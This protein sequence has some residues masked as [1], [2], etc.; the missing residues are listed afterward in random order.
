MEFLKENRRLIFKAVFGLLFIGLA[1]FFIR[2][3]QAEI[4]QVRE[5]LSGANS[6]W[7]FTG[8]L[9]SCIYIVS[10][11][12]MYYTSF[13]SIGKKTGLLTTIRVFLKRNFVSVFLPAGGVA[14]LAFFTKDLERKQISRTQ[15]H[16]ASTIYAFTGIL[17]VII[18][19]IPILSWAMIR[20]SLSSNQGFAFIAV[21]FFV[22]VIGLTIYSLFRQR[23]VYSLILRIWPGI[24]T[25]IVEI[26][27]ITIR[28]RAY[29]STL[30][31]SILIE[32]IGIFTLMIAIKAL[33]FQVSVEVA[34]IGYITSVL[35][36]VVSPFMRGLGAVELSMAF[37]LSRFGFSTVD[38][39]SVTLLYRFFEFWLPLA[40]GGASFLFIR[41]SLFLRI[42]PAVLTFALGIVNI[43]SVLTPAIPVRLELIREFIP[44]YAIDVSNYFVIAMGLFLLVISAFL[45]KGLRT[46]WFLALGLSI[47][48]L[49]GHMV[50]AIDYEEALLAAF[51]AISLI[52]TQ[53]QYF[54]RN[55]H[56]LGQIG[57][58]TAMIS[59]LAV[60][61]YGIIGFY[62]LD[63][64]YFNIDF[65]F[66]QSIEYTLQNFFLFRSE[67]LIP[68]TRFARDFLYSINIA[69]FLSLSFLLYT[70]VR[71]YVFRPDSG[72]NE[73]TMA[74]ELVAKYGKSGLDYF[75]TYSDKLFFFNHEK[76]AFMA[77]RVAGNYAVVLENPVSKDL[78]G[79]KGIIMDFDRFC[80]ENGLKSFYYRVPEE[81]LKVY[82]DLHKKSLLF[83]QEAIIDIENYTIEGG[84]K[85][86]LRNSCNKA[87][88]SGYHIKVNTPPVPDGVLQKLQNVSN[89][90]LKYTGYKELVFSQGIFESAELKNHTILTVENLE[91][92]VEAFTNIIPDSVPGEGTCDL[93]RK[94]KEG[95]N[96]I[97]EFLMVELFFFLKSQG[98]KKVNLGFAPMSG[99][100][101][102]KDF[103]EK[104][105]KFAYERIRTFSHYKGLRDFKEKFAPTWYN[106]YIIYDNH[107]DLFNLTS[108]LNKVFKP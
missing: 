33:G 83:G 41:N 108:I 4:Q 69:G 71:P 37:V 10:Q 67:E 58:A 19:A 56:R 61:S 85:K 38:A 25:L 78:E 16:F 27:S 17:S 30:L 104:S 24:E 18:V 100:D 1:I 75:K 105:I 101:R 5:T 93:I 43:I 40:I 3:E 81:S 49:V 60:V 94:V 52:Y 22:I 70:L 31:T 55:I 39:I 72:L 29:F 14:S 15:I 2:H 103:P 107:Y 102:G 44:L 42:I 59:S 99:I 12:M 74:K 98:Y 51:V 9:L 95:P 20:R 82:E 106:H 96:G 73:R 57:I 28:K 13:R 35:F 45:L 97:I 23:M 89:E 34:M 77:F 68:S 88:E 46:A 53:R 84:A 8:I 11:G 66:L 63:R 36:I 54:V 64:K 79:M 91:E 7:V 50:K 80:N 32:L 65:N 21:V 92:K 47:F 26:K 86:G 48:S 76:N 90:W 62:F 87:R 6:L